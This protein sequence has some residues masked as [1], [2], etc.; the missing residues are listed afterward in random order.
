MLI[1]TGASAEVNSV[2]SI[3]IKSVWLQVELSSP[4]V[5][6]SPVT[7]VIS[8]L[9]CCAARVGLLVTIWMSLSC[10]M[11]KRGG[12]I[13]LLVIGAVLGTDYRPNTH[14]DLSMNCFK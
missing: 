7:S 3:S 11:C 14:E 5:Y 8:A 13:V 10:F 6:L 2:E 4:C 1:F 9:S 12:G